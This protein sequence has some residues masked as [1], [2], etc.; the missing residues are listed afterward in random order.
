MAKTK[1]KKSS[2][3]ASLKSFA[4]KGSAAYPAKFQTDKELVY[5]KGKN[6]TVG[7]AGD[8]AN[9]DAGASAAD[10]S[11]KA[12]IYLDGTLYTTAGGRARVA[13][14]IQT[15]GTTLDLTI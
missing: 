7:G 10:G 8:F 9:P 14:R 13:S 4:R 5:G 3:R 11:G 15:E 6:Y 1:K 12:F 2:R